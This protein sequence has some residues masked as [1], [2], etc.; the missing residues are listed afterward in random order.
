M[1]FY[2]FYKSVLSGLCDLKGASFQSIINRSFCDLVPFDCGFLFFRNFIS[3]SC[4]Y[5]AEY[6]AG[7]DEYVLKLSDSLCI[8]YCIQVYDCSTK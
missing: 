6:V 5:L 3:L 8:C 2:S 1:E 7:S 4:I